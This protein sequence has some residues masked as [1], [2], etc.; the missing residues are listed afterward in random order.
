MPKFRIT[1]PEV[2]YQDYVVEAKDK[3]EV[4]QKYKDGELGDDEIREAGGGPE[5]SH[6]LD[7]ISDDDLLSRVVEEK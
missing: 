7:M 2:W 4:V 3:Q 6:D 5:Y 1:I